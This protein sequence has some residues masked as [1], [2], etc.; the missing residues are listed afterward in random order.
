MP[1]QR[2]YTQWTADTEIAF[3]V[4]LKLHGRATHAAAEIGRTVAA[5]YLRRKR[6][7]D[8]AARWD[9][10]LDE[11]RRR[12]AAESAPPAPD[13]EDLACTAHFDGFT[14]DRRR[15]FLRKLTETGDVEEA[16]RYVRLTAAG[17]YKLRRAHPSF[18][19]A[20]DRAMGQSVATL[21]QAAIDR[22]VDGVEE[23]VWHAGKI[24]GYRVVRSD[25][26]LR[27][28]LQRGGTGLKKGKTKKERI[29]IATEAAK[30]AGGSFIAKPHQ[31]ADDA[32]AALEWKLDRLATK[33]RR[34]EAEEA[35]EQA[36]RWL[37]D[38]KI[39]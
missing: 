37:T 2:P 25:A 8:F 35:A 26:L 38:G 10:A 23:P 22:A 12:T 33:H 13:P 15:A 21:E 6:L 27:T 20:W 11:W 9:A 31:T 30:L 39:P 5:A 24:V 34:E 16:C 4:A 19:A 28:M 36:T 32:F 3:V 1:A 14:R 7:P 18:R 17:A 29:E